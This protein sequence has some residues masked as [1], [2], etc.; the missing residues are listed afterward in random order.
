M[1]RR[2]RRGPLNPALHSSFCILHSSFCIRRRRSFIMFVFKTVR[3]G[4]RVAVW[5]KQG[6]VEF[7]NGPRR[8][9]LRGKTVQPLARYAARAEQYLVVK[10][11]DGRSQHLHGPAAVW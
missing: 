8:L 6:R 3:D 7:V 11:K 4:E 2:L 5:D 9:L 1:Q 10:F